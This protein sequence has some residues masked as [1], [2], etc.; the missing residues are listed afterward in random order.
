MLD[1]N[2]IKE[3]FSIFKNN[4]DL[5]YFDSAATSLTPDV[6]VDAMNDYYKKYPYSVNRGKYKIA[7]EIEQKYNDS[8]QEIAKYFNADFEEIIFTRSTTTSLNYIANSFYNIL[9]EGDEIIISNMEH[10]SNYLPWLELSKNKNIKLKFLKANENMLINIDDID[11]LITSKTK[12]ICIHHVSN[13]I[14]NEV[15]IKAL[16]QKASQNNII[17]VIDGAQGAAHKKIDFKNIGCDFYTISGHKMLGP[18]GIGVLYINKK[19]HSK[20]KPFEYGGDMVVSST[21][22][23]N[24]FTPKK[25]P[26]KYEAGTPSIAEII[27]MGEAIK[28]INNIGIEKIHNHEVKLKKYALSLMENIKDKVEVYNSEVENG[29]IT[30]NIKNSVANHKYVSAEDAINGKFFGKT[31]FDDFSIALRDGQHCNNLTMK[32]VINKGFTLRASF[33]LYNTKKEVEIFVK[34]IEKIYDAWN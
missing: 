20:I 10:H 23:Y 15:D 34:A 17:T 31:D 25:S 24:D 26:F 11:N 6:V 1:V 7:Q 13:V 22:D 32:Y 5:I 28:Y 19:M 18:T 8:R 12:L 30:F 29:I 14:G 2:K 33:Y 16:C 3:D 27:G 21:V 4:K 9:N